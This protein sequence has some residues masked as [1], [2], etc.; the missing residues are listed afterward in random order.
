MLH[1]H[2]S[3]NAPQVFLTPTHLALAMEYA[4]GG[5]LYQHVARRKP[6]P[7]LPEEQARW[8]FQQLIIGLDYCHHQ[9]Q[10]SFCPY[11]FFLFVDFPACMH[12]L[13]YVACNVS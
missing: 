12:A 11:T 10:T 4:P 1:C 8:I 7:W 6:F 3:C 13:A 9:V 5:D 2:C